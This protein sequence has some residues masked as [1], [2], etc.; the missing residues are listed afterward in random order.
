MTCDNQC[1]SPMNH[2]PNLPFY[3]V[4]HTVTYSWMNER[5]VECVAGPTR[6]MR[7]RAALVPVDTAHGGDGADSRSGSKQ[8]GL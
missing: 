1:E 5:C 7:H 8:T 2:D 6:G 3:Q 4:G